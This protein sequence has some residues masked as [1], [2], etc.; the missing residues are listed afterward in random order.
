MALL[1]LLRISTEDESIWELTKG[2]NR[3]ERENLA[4]RVE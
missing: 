1:F 2:N 3:E 4:A